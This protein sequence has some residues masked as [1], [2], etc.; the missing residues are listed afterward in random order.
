LLIVLL[1]LLAVA[2][3][4]GLA[5][6]KPTL[7]S[8]LTIKL[9]AKKLL[10]PETHATDFAGDDLGCITL[11]AWELR[12]FGYRGHA[13][14]CEAAVSGE[15]LGAVLNRAGELRCYITGRYAG[16]FCY[17]FD[18]CGVPDAACVQ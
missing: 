16:D 1:W 14:L 5:E 3:V 15:V 11:T 4:D 7:G 13:F 8:V 17:E 12:N 6:G 2:P 18:I 9:L 10:R